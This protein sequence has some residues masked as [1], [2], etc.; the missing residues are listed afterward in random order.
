MPY[1]KASG[2]TDRYLRRSFNGRAT[3]AR[4]A[5]LPGIDIFLYQS[6]VVVARIWKE[7]AQ[8]NFRPF[9]ARFLRACGMPKEA[10]SKYIVDTSGQFKPFPGSNIPEELRINHI[11]YE[12]YSQAL[13]GRG[14]AP[15]FQRFVKAFFNNTKGL[16]TIEW[17]SIDDYWVFIQD[18]AGASILE[19]FYGPTLLQI[20]PN[21]M[22]TF[23][24]FDVM[25]PGLLKGIPSRKAAGIRESAISQIISWSRYAKAHFRKTSVYEDGDGDPFWGSSWTRYRHEQFSRF[26]GEDSVAS[27]DLGVVWGCVWQP[28]LM[29]ITSLHA[30]LHIAR[31]QTWFPAF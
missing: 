17:K 29:A 25:V 31:Y 7:S 9:A 18:T 3:V 2:L 30:N 11:N 15:T 22:R 6:P 8:L 14:L 12:G 4:L 1:R 23:F 13:T 26:F 24:E 5:I 21:F 20:N 27:I 10:A 16:E 28:L 19:A